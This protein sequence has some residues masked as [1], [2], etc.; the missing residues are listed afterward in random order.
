MAELETKVKTSTKAQKFEYL[1]DLKDAIASENIR[2]VLF[3]GN[4][5]SPSRMEVQLNDVAQEIK[6][7]FLA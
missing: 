1:S 2:V 4:D 6:A 5:R 7:Q 3:I